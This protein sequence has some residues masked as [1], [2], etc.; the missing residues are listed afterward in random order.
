[1]WYSETFNGRAST[2]RK[3]AGAFGLVQDPFRLEFIQQFLTHLGQF[4]VLPQILNRL[5]AETDLPVI[6]GK[7]EQRAV[8]IGGCV[9]FNVAQLPRRESQA[10]GGSADE[11]S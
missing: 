11:E 2:F 9:A 7:L 8:E 3:S 5:G 10:F 4:D 6:L 1:M